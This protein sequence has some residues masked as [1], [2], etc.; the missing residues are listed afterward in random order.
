[1][2]IGT[3]TPRPSAELNV[4]SDNATAGHSA[5]YGETNN[6]D[7]AGVSGVNWAA[8]TAGFLGG[9]ALSVPAGVYGGY[10]NVDGTVRNW[11]AMGG[12]TSAGY[13]YGN[14]IVDSG[15]VGIGTGASPNSP[16]QVAGPVSTAFKSIT[17]DGTPADYTLTADD[18]VI[19]VTSEGI[20]RTVY[21][22]DAG[23]CT[24]RQYTIKSMSS[25]DVHVDGE[26]SIDG[27]D[28]FTLSSIYD[29][30]IVVSDGTNW[31]IVGQN[32]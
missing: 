32:P 21:L 18:S 22:P 8:K 6:G 17:L 15:R 16:L 2:G 7:T 9:Q 14:V 31:L 25:M 12:A 29:Y 28:T 26:D 23:T 1:V 24:G 20:P 11:G 27:G 13:F 3:T 4:Y 10:Y 5:I 30:V 19:A